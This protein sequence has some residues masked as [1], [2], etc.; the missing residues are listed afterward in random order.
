VF[1]EKPHLREDDRQVLKF[2]VDRGGEALLAEI[3]NQFSLPKSTAWRLMR[4]LEREELVEISKFGNQNM[5][6]YKLRAEAH[7]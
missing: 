2:I 3:R 1:V 5:V 7:S 6:R 4:R